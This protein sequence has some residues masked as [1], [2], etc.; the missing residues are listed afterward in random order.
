MDLGFE[1]TP[2]QI[3]KIQ[4]YLQAE[5]D[6][7]RDDFYAASDGYRWG[8]PK[9]DQVELTLAELE[10]IF[11]LKVIEYLHIPT[12]FV[13]MFMKYFNIPLYCKSNFK[14]KRKEDH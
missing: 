13:E 9:T 2:A 3:Q 10:V 11:T 14:L 7:R 5:D 1:F 6:Y 4:N 8:A 12:K